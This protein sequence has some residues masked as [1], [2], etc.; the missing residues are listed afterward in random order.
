MFTGQSGFRVSIGAIISTADQGFVNRQAPSWFLSGD[1][2]CHVSTVDSGVRVHRGRSP[3]MTPSTRYSMSWTAE[4]NVGVTMPW[5][6]FQTICRAFAI[7]FASDAKEWLAI[8]R[9]DR[10]PVIECTLFAGP[11][12]S[13]SRGRFGACGDRE[14]SHFDVARVL[15]QSPPPRS[16]ILSTAEVSWGLVPLFPT[17]SCSRFCC[18]AADEE[19]RH[20]WLLSP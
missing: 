9:P 12:R 8:V 16:V 15:E 18:L 14:R 10:P 5:Q 17:P 1:A 6:K 4:V 11:S 19:P 2:R 13:A 20:R 7:W 3:P